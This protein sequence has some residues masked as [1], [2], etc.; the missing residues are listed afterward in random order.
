MAVN[1]KESPFTT[2]NMYVCLR[3]SPTYRGI[4]CE[5]MT[6]Y[7]FSFHKIDNVTDG[8]TPTY[9]QTVNITIQLECNTYKN[10]LC[11]SYVFPLYFLYHLRAAPQAIHKILHSFGNGLLFMY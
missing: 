4:F 2:L 6:N 5:R 10:A 8:H 7:C 3:N 9:G 1:N 11:I